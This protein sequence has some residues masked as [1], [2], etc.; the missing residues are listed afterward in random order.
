MVPSSYWL[1]P[2]VSLQLNRL[3]MIHSEKKDYE[4]KGHEDGYLSILIL[5]SHPSLSSTPFLY[6][7]L[8]LCAV[9]CAMCIETAWVY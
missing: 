3:Y 7:Y 2:L 5:R 6:V 9:Y 8:T 1:H 4:T